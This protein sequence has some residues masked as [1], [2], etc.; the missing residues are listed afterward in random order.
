MAGNDGTNLKQIVEGLI[1]AA[2]EPISP[3][4]IRELVEGAGE[5]GAEDS[6]VLTPQALRS[7]VDALN[8]DY[9]HGGRPYRIQAVAGGYIF[10]TNR[11]VSAFVGKL[12]REQSRRR[13]TQAALETL[14][15]IAYKQPITKVELEAIR[16]VNSD[17]IVKSLLEKDLITI[18]GRQQ[19]PGRPLLYGTTKRFLMHFGLDSLT[20]LPKPREIEELIGETELEVEKRMLE[21]E[22]QRQEEEESAAQK[23]ERKPHPLAEGATA[24]II[25]LKPDYRP[26]KRHEPED[27][28]PEAPAGEA[29]ETTV[30]DTAPAKEMPQAEAPAP[31]EDTDETDVQRDGTETPDAH[32]ETE[33]TGLPQA[34]ASEPASEPELMKEPD[35][36]DAPEQTEAPA[37]GVPPHAPGAA[38]GE[39]LPGE[40]E[41]GEKEMQHGW[42]KWKSKIV[43]IIKKI[44]G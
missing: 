41:A 34:P 20:D 32:D 22:K 12:H 42:R 24:K 2:D 29:G 30:Q 17:Y 5:N 38:A 14:A 23:R 39:S 9:E 44:F 21:L 26:L 28:E 1:F 19:S 36:P 25:P 35:P 18:T 40:A 33:A 15:I 31:G 27:A 6:S 3:K 10:A 11:E 43:K 37:A 13:L 7:I 16:G 4:Q 8:G